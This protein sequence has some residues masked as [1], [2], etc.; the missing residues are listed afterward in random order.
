[1]ANKITKEQLKDLYDFLDEECAT[2]MCDNTLKLTLRW[3][4]ENNLSD[5]K[6]EIIEYL[7]NHG[8][9]CDCEVIFNVFN[10]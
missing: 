9:Y 7:E 5:R 1:M 6:D 2:I 10:G 4:E 8:G 3:I